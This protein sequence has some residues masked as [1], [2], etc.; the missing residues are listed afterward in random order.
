M[1][2]QD[3]LRQHGRLR[4]ASDAGDDEASHKQISF[5]TEKV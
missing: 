3:V 2:D 5:F 4:T 1:D